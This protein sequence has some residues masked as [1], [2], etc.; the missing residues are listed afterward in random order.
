MALDF[1][2][3]TSKF[4]S[5]KVEQTSFEDDLGLQPKKS[6]RRTV[7]MQER[8]DKHIYKRAHS[9]LQL[10]NCLDDEKLKENHTYN[11]I[12]SGDV[13]SLSYLMLALRTFKELDYLLFSTWC[14]SY[15][16]ILY[17]FDLVESGKVKKMDAYVGEIFPN[18][19]KFEWEKINELFD[20]YKCGRIVVFK[21]HSKIFAGLKGEKGFSIQSSANINTNPRT[22][23]GS[24]TVSKESALFYKEY[25]DGIKSF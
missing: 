9:E 2:L 7:H 8:T 14:M 1:K 12:T 25:F 16:D 11:F 24:I 10:L 13:D 21:N 17:L 5:K 19:Y 22:E 3:K 4:Q 6:H 18:S 20:K 15:E 23:N